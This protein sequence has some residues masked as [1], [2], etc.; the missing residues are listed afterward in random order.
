MA[1]LEFFDDFITEVTEILESLDQD[2]V[3][4]ESRADDL[5]LLNKIFRA[6]HTIKGTSSFMGF[7][8]MMTITHKMEDILNIL[9]SGKAKVTPGVMDVILEAVDVV[10]SIV[11]HLKETQ[12]EPD[13]DISGIVGKLE[14]VYQELRIGE[15][16]ASSASELKI[17]EKTQGEDIV[18][19][20]E[21]PLSREELEAFERE[22][23]ELFKAEL[24]KEK[25][26][27]VSEKDKDEAK[28]QDDKKAKENTIRVDISRLDNLM[29]LVGELVLGRNRLLRI[30]QQLYQKYDQD[31]LV[32]QLV[33][34]MDQ[35]DFITTDLQFAVMKTRMVPIGRV[36]SRFPRV[37]RDVARELRKEVRLVIEG[38]DTELDRSIVDEINDPLVH[39]VRNAIDH[40]IEYPE[41]RE[42]LGKLRE[43]LLRLKAY[44][45]GN[46][47]VIVVEDDGRGIDVE[48]V[49]RKAI[50]RGIISPEEAK[51]MTENDALNLIFLPGFSTAEKVSSVSGRGVG[52]DVVRVCVEKLNG[53]IEVRSEKGKGTQIIMKIPLTL[54]IIQSLL[55]QV[56]EEIYAIP[57]VSVVEAVRLNE[58]NIKTV[59]NKEVIVLRDTVLP[60][61][62]L[63]NIFDVPG[64]PKV[65]NMYVVVIA[66][67]EKRFGLVVD[68]LIGQEEVV[69]KSLG[70]YLG[71]VEGIAGATIMGD[72]R[73]TLIL[74]VAGIVNM[75]TYSY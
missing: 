49:K 63:R 46:H 9:R 31:E 45:E 18:I 28:K 25:V 33:E 34:T 26:K 24:E 48:K 21:K 36:F 50:E 70:P 52:M 41:E 10:K 19:G 23:E 5:D 40:G 57:L 60:L 20:G 72:G 30:V 38:E 59:E 69:I 67:G 54:A 8:R 61:V 65:K 7:T 2:L 11:D 43:G 74:D 42:I 22:I 27:T 66:I 37:V 12:E 71:S 47:I 13:I 39:L 68:R 62:R 44:H 29:N 32:Q 64:E 53:T 3:E 35:V 56:D 6:A 75:L 55:V 73:V 1:E 51:R 15:D 14:K 4:L 16:M 58:E 17:E